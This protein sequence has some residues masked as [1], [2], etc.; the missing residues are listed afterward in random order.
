M[1]PFRNL[2]RKLEIEIPYLMIFYIQ[3][4]TVAANERDVVYNGGKI[5]SKSLFT[6]YVF[7]F[8]IRY[9]FTI[10]NLGFRI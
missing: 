5:I 8:K 4:A 6:I 2:N 10:V 9:G 7:P 1:D 3:F